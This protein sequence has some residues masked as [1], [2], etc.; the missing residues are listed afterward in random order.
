MVFSEALRGR[1]ERE[2]GKDRR[3]AVERPGVDTERFHAASDPAA[4]A[5]GP[6][7][8]RLLFVG[9][10]FELKGLRPLLGALAIHRAR[11]GGASLTVVGA[12]PIGRFRRVA[13]RR[14]V[15]GAVSFAG[16]VPRDAMPALYRR[17]HAL[18]HP[19]F[20]DPFSLVVVEALAS[21]IPAVTTG[22]NGASE[23]IEDGR[24]GFLVD[25]P[26]DE[27]A[28]AGTLDRLA[29]RGIRI[30]MAG[31]AAHLGR[32]F[33]AREH[34]ARVLAWLGSGGRLHTP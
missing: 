19:T 1:I 10:S 32:R 21:G 17:H 6:S 5:G 2:F 7:P 11:G 33:D 30:P 22:R 20:Y 27:G 3:I 14:G 9:H 4:D 15:A 18:I 24:E 13:A 26:R 29:D 25:D 23:I 34:F 31:N 8:L 28:L 12:G 16:G